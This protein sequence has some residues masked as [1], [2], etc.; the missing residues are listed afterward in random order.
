MKR[1]VRLTE[2]DLNQLIRTAVGKALNEA[3]FGGGGN[4]IINADLEG[5]K[6]DKQGRDYAQQLLRNQG[7]KNN[8]N[9][10]HFIV[11]KATGKIVGGWDYSGEDPDDLRNFKRD[12][13]INDMIDWEFNPKE[14]KVVGDKFLR[15]Q[16]IDPDDNNNW[17][18]R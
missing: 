11:N 9:Y 5:T 7:F 15:R 14:Y 17:S 6:L 13:F 1:I 16:G 8:M 3:A 18:N 12:Y 10:T 2:S 4:G